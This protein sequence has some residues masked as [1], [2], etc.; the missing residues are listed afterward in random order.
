[1][2]R[3]PARYAVDA[4]V[5]LRYLLRDNEE[6]AQKALAIWRAV[7]NGQVVAAL[8]PVTLGEVVFV[9]SL[10]YRFSNAEI[11]EALTPLLQSNGV[12]IT[13][14]ERYLRALRLFA[15]TVKHFGDACA[16]AA[17]LEDCEGRLYSFDRKLSA[18]EGIE[19]GETVTG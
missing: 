10:V 6:L 5:I 11:S 18:V 17:A 4:N 12:E 1:M 16:C 15:R 3:W 9:M 19:R 8:D 2:S 7:E 13:G 14:K